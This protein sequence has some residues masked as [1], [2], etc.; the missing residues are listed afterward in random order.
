MTQPIFDVN[1][2]AHAEYTVRA[3]L[4]KL[5]YELLSRNLIDQSKAH[6][7]EYLWSVV[8]DSQ[9]DVFDNL[10]VL[11]EIHGEFKKV[12]EYAILNGNKMV[13]VILLATSVEHV[14]NLY[15]REMLSIKN[16]PESEITEII[17]SSNF[18]T[19]LGWLMSIVGNVNLHKGMINNLKN[20][21]DARNAIVHYKAVPGKLD[22]RNGSDD[23]IKAKLKTI[24][25]P[26]MLNLLDELE[27]LFE[28]GL[29]AADPNRKMAVEF[30][31]SMLISRFGDG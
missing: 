8:T 2:A 17:R 6:D 31:H 26:E 10:K 9:N 29:D 4:P 1:F 5:L 19:K 28:A 18:N 23:S 25:L 14:L 15:Y 16:L 30:A 11:T 20:L 12:T 27:A 3:M 13:S 24:N 22:V 7:V 21:I